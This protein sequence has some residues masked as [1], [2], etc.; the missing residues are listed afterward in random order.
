MQIEK[1]TMRKD[2]YVNFLLPKE[3]KLFVG[4]RYEGCEQGPYWWNMKE[5]C[6]MLES[7]QS[8]T[9]NDS[10]FWRTENYGFSGGVCFDY[11]YKNNCV[12]FQ[13]VAV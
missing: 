7:D 8:M 11:Q 5:T 2:Y 4:I 12:R 13:R 9:W 3:T 6:T 10:T 1:K